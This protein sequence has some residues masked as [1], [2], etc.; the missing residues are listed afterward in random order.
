VPTIPSKVVAL[1]QVLQ[2]CPAARHYSA[3]ANVC[4]VSLEASRA[5]DLDEAL[6]DLEMSG[7]VLNGPGQGFVRV[8]SRPSAAMEEHV[9][10]ALDP[11]GKFP[12]LPQSRR[13]DRSVR[14]CEEP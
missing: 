13:A 1:D 7:L 4:Y 10:T 2:T 11:G 6:E 3:G 14:T 8:G 9:K 5:D 12:E